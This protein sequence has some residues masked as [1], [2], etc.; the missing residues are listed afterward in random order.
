MTP[1]EQIEEI[2]NRETRAWDTQDVELL[3]TIF[4][5]DAVWPWPPTP[6]HHDPIDWILTQ[7]RFNYD[8]W[9]SGWQ[10]LFASFDLI[11]NN[12]YVRKIQLSDQLDGAFAV[13]DIDTLWRN[14]SDCKD[15]LWKGRTCKI[16]S[17]VGDRWLMTMQTGVLDYTSRN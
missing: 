1:T 4:H 6:D 13:V 10:N 12:R 3:L 16:Y 5:P 7:G 2:I 14:R 15:F 8:R 9:R 11:H 17:R